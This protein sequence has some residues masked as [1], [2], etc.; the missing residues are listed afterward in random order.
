M[1]E[2]GRLPSANVGFVLY[3]CGVPVNDFRYLG[4]ESKVDLDWDDPWYSRFEHRNLRRQYD[5]PLCVFLYVES[6]EIRKEIVVRPKDLQRWVDLGLEG[7][8]A[9]TVEA[10][11]ELK[12]KVAEFLAERSPVTVDNRPVDG[13]LDRIHFVRRSLRTTGVVDPPEELDLNTATLGV[14]FVYPIGVLPQEASLTWDL[15]G[16]KIPKVPAAATDEAGGMPFTLTRED[17]E[18]RWQNFLTNPTMPVMMAV[19]PPESPT[20]SFPV[21][22]GIC[23]GLILLLLP[24][25]F[26]KAKKKRGIPRGIILAGAVTVVL[27]VLSWPYAR[28]SLPSPLAR[29]P[30][31]ESQQAKDVLHALLYNVYRAFDH[32]DES[33]VYDRL[34]LSISGDLLT[35]IY[36]QVRRS[37]ELENQGGA[38]VKVDEVRIL[39]V[40]E[41]EELA[42]PGLA[43]QCRW[44]AAGSVGHW[45]HV[46]RR[47]NQYDAVIT[48][49]PVEE[50][51]KITALDVREE[52]RV[53][54]SA[55][56]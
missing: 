31:M 6:F 9:I 55:L 15:F 27:G 16:P 54:P 53:D 19:M 47:T 46:H 29:G 2:D 28:A 8:E 38:R 48:I 56:Q 30:A 18:L 39:D 13:R 32:R 43:Y 17:P 5:A 24:V 20:I 10:Q 26:S 44:T 33:L 52:Q 40:T 36:L 51:W 11:E 3:H 41:E 21:I 50:V 1:A 34:A 22:S 42:R 7:K 23:F 49:E 45:G 4:A 35:D 12:Q 25:G 14:I 37:M